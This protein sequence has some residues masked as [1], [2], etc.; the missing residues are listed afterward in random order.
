MGIIS[1]LQHPNIIQFYGVTKSDTKLEDEV[2]LN[3]VKYSLVLEYANGGTLESYLR[4]NAETFKWEN[5]LR[6]AKEIAD[7]ISWCHNKE[8]IHGDLHS[9]NILIHQ[10]QPNQH[11]IKLADFGRSFIQGSKE[12]TKAYG[13]VPYMDPKIFESQLYNLTKKSDIYSLGV[14]LWQLTSCSS[15]FGF[16]EIEDDHAKIISLQLDILKGE[17]ENPVPHTNRK[18]VEVFQKCWQLEPDERSDIHEVISE[19]KSID[20]VDPENNIVSNNFYSKESEVTE[21][22]ENEDS[23]LPNCEDCD[24]HSDR[25]QL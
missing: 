2:A 24:I 23:D 6:F 14:L 4:D 25:Y 10:I 7:A 5:Q 3:E 20:S 16:A 12:F 11:A 15:P 22:L 9:K 21:K 13:V 18:F 1:R 8:I 17:R 19:L